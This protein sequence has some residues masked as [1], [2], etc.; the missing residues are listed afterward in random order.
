MVELTRRQRLRSAR[1]AELIELAMILPLLLLLIGGI[2]DFAFMFQAFEAVNNAAREGARVSV[3]PGYNTTDVQNRVAAYITAAGLNSANATT[4]RN[5]VTLSA[6]QGGGSSTSPGYEVRVTYTH[7]FTMLGPLV[8]LASAGS[9][10]NSV[11]LVAVST[12][13]REM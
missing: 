13:R 4:A 8:T 11:N 10:P 7:T 1:G 6:A 2:V 9:F 3:L 5:A 12:M